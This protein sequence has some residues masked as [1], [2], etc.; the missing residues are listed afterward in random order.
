MHD[1]TN[2]MTCAKRILRSI[3]APA[4]SD[5]SFR[6]PREGSLD[7]CLP[8]ERT[9]KTLI[10]LGWCPGWSDSS[11]GAQVILLVLSCSGSYMSHVTTKPVFRV[12]DELRLKPACSARKTSFGLE[13]SAFASRGIVLSRQRT[14]KAV[15][16]LC[17]WACYPVFE[18][19][20]SPTLASHG[21]VGLAHSHFR[22]FSFIFFPIWHL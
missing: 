4:Q 15:V 2:K 10:R 8:S 21:L 20:T 18:I 1:K 7:H 11:L 5:Q 22:D 13:I 3:W 12:G 16:I 6:W 19:S 17:G 9:A 14:T